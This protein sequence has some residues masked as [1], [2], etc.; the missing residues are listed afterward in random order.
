MLTHAEQ[1]FS[2]TF[3]PLLPYRLASSSD[4][5]TIGSES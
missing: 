4:D 2:V 1:V 5:A 3:S